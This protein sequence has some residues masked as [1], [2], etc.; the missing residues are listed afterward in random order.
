MFKNRFLLLTV[1]V[2]VVLT[3]GVHAATSVW[4]AEKNGN[5]VYLGGTV[6]VLSKQDYPLPCEFDR[7]FEASDEL[8]FEIDYA[9]AQAPQ[10]AMKMATQLTYSDGRSLETV[11]EKHT[12]QKLEAYFREAGIPIAMVSRF[13]PGM[14]LS[15]MMMHEMKK[16]NITAQGVDQT[17]QAKAMS[18]NKESNELESIDQQIAFLGKLGEGR[19]DEFVNYLLDSIPE[20]PIQ[21]NKLMKAWRSGDEETLNQVSEL[22][23]MKQN[24]PEVYNTLILDRNKK[25]LAALNQFFKDDDVEYVLVGAAHM[26]G[27]DGLLNGLR[28]QGAKITHAECK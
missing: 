16:M 23:E 19:E 27:E 4:K 28:K 22:N 17:F 21:F 13:K 20:L 8:F 25:W 1:L 7:A 3:S 11:L 18:A 24:F 2:C 14:L 6:H 5:T 26:V 10:N 15:F 9:E 12:Y